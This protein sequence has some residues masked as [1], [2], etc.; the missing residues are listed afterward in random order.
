MERVLPGFGR[1]LLRGPNSDP[2]DDVASFPAGADM[3]VCFGDVAEV[4][5]PVDDGAELFGFCQL[6]DVGEVSGDERDVAGCRSGVSA[7]LRPESRRERR[8]TAAGRP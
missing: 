7:A 3:P 4:E 1:R 6:C 2:H 8:P 5:G